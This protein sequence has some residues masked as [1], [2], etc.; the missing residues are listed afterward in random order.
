MIWQERVCSFLSSRI[1]LRCHDCGCLLPLPLCI[2]SS[3]RTYGLSFFGLLLRQGPTPGRFDGTGLSGARSSYCKA[4]WIISV[5]RF[6][7]DQASLGS[8]D[9]LIAIPAD[10]GKYR[11]LIDRTARIAVMVH[12]KEVDR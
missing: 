2:T 9:N 3:R 5:C 11:W 12:G 10:L 8:S 1:L 7:Q 6:H 4:T